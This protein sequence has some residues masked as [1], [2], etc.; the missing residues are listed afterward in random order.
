MRALPQEEAA[1]PLEGERLLCGLTPQRFVAAAPLTGVSAS[2]LGAMN[3]VLGDEDGANG[4][5]LLPL[6]HHGS[7]LDLLACGET[8]GI[9]ARR[10]DH[11]MLPMPDPPREGYANGPSRP[12]PES[13]GWESISLPVKS[14]LRNPKAVSSA[15]SVSSPSLPW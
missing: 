7:S 4:Q 13:A 5:D 6:P 1:E 11:N 9:G 14:A 12:Q 3:V 8:L 10:P 15:S 2:K